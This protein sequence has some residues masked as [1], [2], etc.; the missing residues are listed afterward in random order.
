MSVLGEG[1]DTKQ[2]MNDANNTMNGERETRDDNNVIANAVER[3]SCEIDWAFE[4][5]L[6]TIIDVDNQETK[7][8]TKTKVQGDIEWDQ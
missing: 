7:V 2:T 6:L 3:V 4:V 8:Y 1:W 5:W